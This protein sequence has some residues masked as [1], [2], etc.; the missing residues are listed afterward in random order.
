MKT[1]KRWR[2]TGQHKSHE[3]TFYLAQEER[4]NIQPTVFISAYCS[5]KA[6]VAF[7]EKT[8]KRI[9]RLLNA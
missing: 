3:L 4:Q 5:K 8:V 6:D 7:I 2:I 1:K 9:E